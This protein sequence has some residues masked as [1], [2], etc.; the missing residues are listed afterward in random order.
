MHKFAAFTEIGPPD[1]ENEVLQANGLTNRAVQGR[2]TTRVPQLPSVKIWAQSVSN[3]WGNLSRKKKKKEEETMN[4]QTDMNTLIPAPRALGFQKCRDFS[5]STKNSVIFHIF[6]RIG[7]LILQNL[8]ELNIMIFCC[9][10]FSLRIFSIDLVCLA[11]FR[12]RQ[13]LP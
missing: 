7:C 4:R 13:F 3:S 12:K 2:F 9:A 11:S 8:C 10:Y 5:L 6:K 1:T